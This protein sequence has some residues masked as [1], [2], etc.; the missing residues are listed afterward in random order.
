MIAR[1]HPVKGQRYFIDAAAILATRHPTCKFLLVGAGCDKGNMELLAQLEKKGLEASVMLLGERSDV[2]KV[3]NALDVAVCASISESFPNAVGEAM[4]CG[5]PCIV[6]DVGDC[7]YL[8]GDTGWVVP[9]A[10]PVALAKAM[11]AAVQAPSSATGL[12]SAKARERIVA[13]FSLDRITREYRD[14][15]RSTLAESRPRP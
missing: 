2:A 5:V 1:Y 6:T 10:D 15:Y 11:E 13:L 9:V 7:A 8:V 4:A 14:L 3:V 12:R